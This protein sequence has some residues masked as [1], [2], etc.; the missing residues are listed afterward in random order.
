LIDI[1]IFQTF[2]VL[3]TALTVLGGVSGV[4][5]LIKPT[6]QTQTSSV[7]NVY[8][9]SFVITA[10]KGAPYLAIFKLVYKKTSFFCCCNP[11]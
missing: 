8:S 6:E 9:F 5:N 4:A 1:Y 3:N 11:K 7:C 10:A 2:V